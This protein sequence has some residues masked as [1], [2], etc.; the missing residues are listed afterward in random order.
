MDFGKPVVTGIGRRP[1]PITIRLLRG[2][3]AL[4]GVHQVAVGHQPGEQEHDGS[5]VGGTKV[6]NPLYFA[7]LMECILKGF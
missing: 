4:G 5:L 2:D 1:S 3:L 7:N 6:T